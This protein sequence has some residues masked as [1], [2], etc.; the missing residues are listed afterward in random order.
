MKEEK[1]EL[2]AEKVIERLLNR[3][4]S[5]ELENAKLAVAIE[6]KGNEKTTDK[7]GE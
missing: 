1:I 6:A 2:D 4:A 7:E 3:I 5:L